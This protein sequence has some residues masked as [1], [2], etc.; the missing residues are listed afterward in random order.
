VVTG[1]SGLGL[2][3]DSESPPHATKSDVNA[4]KR[5][6]LKIKKHDFCS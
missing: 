2:G 5:M 3:S 4:K 6:D 1:G